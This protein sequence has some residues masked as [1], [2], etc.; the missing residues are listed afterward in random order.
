V[1]GVTH[2][3]ERLDHLQQHTRAAL[4]RSAHVPSA[5]EQGLVQTHCGESAMVLMVGVPNNTVCLL[6]V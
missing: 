5:F 3:C 2:L 1:N 6:Q 4:A